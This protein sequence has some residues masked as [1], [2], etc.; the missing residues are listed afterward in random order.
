MPHQRQ[1]HRPGSRPH[2]SLGEHAK[3][4]TVIDPAT[5]FTLM[6]SAAIRAGFSE[7]E[8]NIHELLAEGDSVVAR[9]SYHVTR[10]DGS[11]R[12]DR[13]WLLPNCL[14]FCGPPRLPRY[15]GSPGHVTLPA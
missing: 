2:H 1:A 15:R 7:F 12:T 4:G 5:I 13:T 14:P 3:P 11:T 6:P 8:F 10:P 9:R